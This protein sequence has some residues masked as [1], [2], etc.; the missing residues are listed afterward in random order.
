MPIKIK[1]FVALFYMDVSNNEAI[2][3]KIIEKSLELI[4]MK[5]LK[6]EGISLS[7]E[8]VNLIIR[9]INGDR[10]NLKNELEKIKLLKL[11]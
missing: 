9:K 5:E 11:I 7:K 10:I 1:F 2:K 4:T 6:K 3:M 8:S